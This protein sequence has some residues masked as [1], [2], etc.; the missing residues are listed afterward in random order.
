M[1]YFQLRSKIQNWQKYQGC[2][3]V[4]RAPLINAGFPGNFNLSFTEHHW[5]EEYGK[6]V[7]F[8]HNFIF[9]TVQS[10][11]RPDD[12]ELTRTD[13]S[14]KYLG[15]FEIA[16]LTGAIAL[17][18]RFSKDTIH[19]KQIFDLIQFLKELGISPERMHPSYCVG[20]SV[21]ALTAGK[22]DFDH[23]IPEDKISRESFLDA[24]IPE[25]NLIPD[26]TTN[27]FLSIN[28]RKKEQDGSISLAYN[29]W[30]YRNEL[31]IMM[32]NGR[33]LDIGTLERF[34]WTPIWHDEQIVRLKETS[35]VFSIL[36]VGLERLCMVVNNLS[37]VQ[38]VDHISPFYQRMRELTGIEDILAG[39]SLRTIHRIY[40]DVQVYHCSPSRHH[41]ARIRKLIKNIPKT[42]NSDQIRQLLEKHTQKQH[43]HPELQEGIEPTIKRIEKYRKIR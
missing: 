35:C 21:R 25:E 30:G 9:S 6:L 40:S 29:G 15:V 39:E 26:A 16:D 11:I 33:L 17:K 19:R 7:D 38:D 12:V 31:N 18:E 37:R 24:R 42:I 14:W 13:R 4:D 28:L 5:L 32:Q 22:Y 27:T 1:Q 2:V 10:C 3:K 43:W 41:D 36:A 23:K 8:D 20:G 34:A